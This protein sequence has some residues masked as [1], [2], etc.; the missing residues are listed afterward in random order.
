[1]L[2]LLFV[3][4]SLVNIH[5]LPFRVLHISV[6]DFS[7][8]LSLL[9]MIEGLGIAMTCLLDPTGAPRSCLPLLSVEPSEKNE[10]QSQKLERAKYAWSTRYLVGGDAS[11]GS[12]RVAAPIQGVCGAP[13]DE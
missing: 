12:C 11:H 1:M 7:F 2:V 9:F 3:A 5:V 6:P 8:S 4:T 13:M 10:S